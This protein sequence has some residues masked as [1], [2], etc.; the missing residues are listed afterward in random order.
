MLLYPVV[1]HAA[2]FDFHPEVLAFPLVMQCV[3]LLERRAPKDD[4]RVA[5]LLLLVLTC[6]V[7][8]AFLVLGFAGS[9]L[10]RRRWGLGSV[11]ALE[12]LLWFVCVG[13]W[14]MP[15]FG[16]PRASLWRQASKFGLGGASGGD[17]PLFTIARHLF[18]LA[19]L[20]YLLLLLVPVLYVLLHGRNLAFLGRLLPAAPLVLINLAAAISPMKDLAHHYSL[21]LVP[22]LAGGVQATLAP[23]LSG[24]QAYPQWFRDRA[25]RLV[26]VWGALAFVVFS[27]LSFHIGQLQD[28]WAALAAMRDV[29]PMVSAQS[30]LL[31]NNSL[32]PH[33]SQRR[34]IEMAQS[35]A[36]RLDLGRFDQ[37]LLDERHPG[38]N[39]S[40]E[41]VREIRSRL[42]ASVQWQLRFDRDGVW[43]FERRPSDSDRMDGFR[44][45]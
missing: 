25:P 34:V 4:A 12:A 16:G 11:L 20:E 31:T 22:F 39:A 42:A 44:Q 2:I 23:G 40:P 9:V 45:Q 6:K 37:V 36:A 38:L 10:L 15:A 26:L 43:L 28:R 33:F 32:A 30:R 1:F 18:S 21:M 17:G 27:R 13:G 3:L 14:L 8:L 41:L 19:N 5:L 24:V 35:G 7:V 29:A